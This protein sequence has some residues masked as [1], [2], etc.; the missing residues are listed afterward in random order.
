MNNDH[1]TLPTHLF[2]RA[3]ACAEEIRKA[4]PTVPVSIVQYGIDPDIWG[5]NVGPVTAVAEDMDWQ[6]PKKNTEH[7]VTEI[8]AK[9][10]ALA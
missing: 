1:L 2:G 3:V 8:L 4:H 9:Y 6:W 7:L 5:L 10:R